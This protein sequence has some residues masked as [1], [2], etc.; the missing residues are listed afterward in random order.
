M[1]SE[2]F[3]TGG[4]G[5]LGGHLI[6][7]LVEEG[8]TVRALARSESARDAVTAKGASSIEAD[9]FDTKALRDGMWGADVVFH[10]AGI[11]E[12]CPRNRPAMDRVNIEGTVSIVQ[13][14]AASGVRRVVFTSSATA[15]GELQGTIGTEH[16][17][18]S[19]EYLSAYARS[20][21]LAE[22]AA[23]AEADR[24]GVELVAVLPSSVQGPGRATGSA[25]LL[26]RSL[27]SRRPLL[28]DATLSIVD[29]EDCTTGHIRAAEYGRAGERYI[30]SGATLKVTDA[31]VLLSEVVGRTISPRWLSEGAVRSVGM[32]AARVAGVVRPSVGVCPALIRTLLHGHRFDGSKASTDLRF[33]Y[34][35]MSD[36]MTRT[37]AWFRGQGLIRDG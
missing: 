16:T 23:F 10:V 35:E 22:V 9:L 37:V 27:N 19:G 34:I 28:F 14:A 21:H 17:V 5:I 11:N 3:V 13:A 2:V 36:T 32:A 6:S 24:L 30:L 1:P 12:T 18:H 33:A 8:G 31:V 29:I 25:A 26:L 20:K 15:V 7:R 4:S